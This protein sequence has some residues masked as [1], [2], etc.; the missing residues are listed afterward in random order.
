[1]IGKAAAKEWVSYTLSLRQ[2]PLVKRKRKRMLI[3]VRG[4]LGPPAYLKGFSVDVMQ[5]N[6]TSKL[7]SLRTQ[8]RQLHHVAPCRWGREKHKHW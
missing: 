7:F 6:Y 1:M 5:S 8:S 4:G 3:D 2:H